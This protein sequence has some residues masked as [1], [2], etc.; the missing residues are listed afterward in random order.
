M[1]IYIIFAVRSLYYLEEKDIS[2]ITIDCV[3]VYR[4]VWEI[5]AGL[6]VWIG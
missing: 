1:W 6:P 4:A 5:M 2:N 3:V